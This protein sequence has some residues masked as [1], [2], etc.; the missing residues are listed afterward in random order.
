MIIKAFIFNNLQMIL[1]VKF[2]IKNV[3]KNPIKIFR[4]KDMAIFMKGLK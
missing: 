1:K 2:S 4:I 3:Q